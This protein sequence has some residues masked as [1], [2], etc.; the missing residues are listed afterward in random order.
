MAFLSADDGFRLGQR[1]PTLSDDYAPFVGLMSTFVRTRFGEDTT[2]AEA[3]RFGYFLVDGQ[4]VVDNMADEDQRKSRELALRHGFRF[5]D[6]DTLYC[7]IDWPA[8]RD[9]LKGTPHANIDLDE[10]LLRLPLAHRPI[11]DAGN[12]VRIRFAGMVKRVIALPRDTLR[13]MGLFVF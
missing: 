5:A 6:D 13:R 10:Y 12:H 2:V 8:M 4:F 9:L 3:L 7:A 11:N 1:A